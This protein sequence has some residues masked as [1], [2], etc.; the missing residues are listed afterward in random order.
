LIDDGP[1]SGAELSD[2][3][4]ALMLSFAAGRE[5]AFVEL[6]RR[7]RNR[8]VTFATRMLGD[9]ARAEEAAQ[10]V[11]LKLYRARQTY[12]VES[13]FAT[14]LYRIATNHCLNQRARI[15]HHLTQHNEAADAAAHGVDQHRD[16]ANRQLQVTI[17]AALNKLPERQRAAFLLV[18]YDGLSYRE[19]A[20]SLDVSEAALK[21][22][23]H[24][25]RG[26]LSADLAPVIGNSEIDYAV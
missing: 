9:Q 12:K 22:L 20:E 1:T 5:E 7:Y 2:D 14:F 17:A 23:I 26:A 16:Y 21:S 15:E 18:H 6:Y 4:A 3:D 25:S 8:I 24:R 11:F 19:A 10:D 13:R